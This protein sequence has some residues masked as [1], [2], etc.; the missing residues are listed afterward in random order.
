[1]WI[2]GTEGADLVSMTFE[3]VRSQEASVAIAFNEGPVAAH[4]AQSSAN[5]PSRSTNG[6][7][8]SKQRRSSMCALALGIAMFAHTSTP[9]I[10][11]GPTGQSRIDI[12]PIGADLDEKLFPKTLSEAD[13]EKVTALRGHIRVMAKADKLEAA[14]K[15]EEEAMQILGYAKIWLRCGAGTFLWMKVSPRQN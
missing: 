2:K 3:I 10:A 15:A 12:P 11:C 5:S 1:M 14:R 6:S 9:A 13:R 8:S 7:G 4:P